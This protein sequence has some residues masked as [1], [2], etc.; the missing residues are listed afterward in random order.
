MDDPLRL[1]SEDLEQGSQ[2][3][4]HEKATLK[5]KNIFEGGS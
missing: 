5:K 2:T 4:T 3:Q 1:A